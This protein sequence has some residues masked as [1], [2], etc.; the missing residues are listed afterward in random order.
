MGN[1]LFTHIRAPLG[2]LSD[3]HRQEYDVLA[4]HSTCVFDR[5]RMQLK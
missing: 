3:V 2:D 5:V 1:L 4:Y